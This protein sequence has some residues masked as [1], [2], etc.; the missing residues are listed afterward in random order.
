MTAS[1]T[2][3]KTFCCWCLGALPLSLMGCTAGKHVRRNFENSSTF[4]YAAEPIPAENASDGGPKPLVTMVGFQS[5]VSAARDLE[6][7]DQTQRAE[8]V[9]SPLTV[10]AAEQGGTPLS[11]ARTSEQRKDATS[12]S[13]T[14]VGPG[15]IREATAAPSIDYAVD[16]Y[17]AIDGYTV[18]DYVAMAIAAHPK[19][20]AANHR[21]AAAQNR[22]AQARSLAD[23]MLSETFWPFNG[24]A[25]E[26]A[27]GRAANQL[28]ISQAVPWPEKL[29]A[30][31]AIACREAQVV[32]AEVRRI[33]L[34]IVESVQLACYEIWFATR[35]LAVVAESGKLVEELIDI[36]EAR[37]RSGGSQQ[38]ILRAQ[39][40]A[41]R[42]AER[43]SQLQQQKRVAQADLATLLQTPRESALEVAL[44]S[45]GLPNLQDLDALIA[46]A[47]SNNPELRGLRSQISSDRAK[48]RLA[49]LQKYPDFQVGMN[50]MMVSDQNAISPV[51]NGND[52]FGFTVGMSLPIYREKIDAGIRESAHMTSSTANLLQSERDSIAGKLRRLLAQADSLIEQEQIYS[53]RIIP[54][55]E[56]A[57]KVSLA[58][59]RGKKTDFSSVIETYRELLQLQIQLARLD[60]SLAA[61]IAQVERTIGIPT[62]QF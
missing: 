23:P 12:D 26:T 28:G 62:Y 25:L 46:Q 7:N 19:I 1:N 29:A 52:N 2:L 57:L 44:D 31:E 37:Y 43:I 45:E 14:P 38:D 41:D 32:E 54:R 18:D 35:S 34:E 47:E 51:A 17:Y 8:G 59:Y 15:G 36:S 24:N 58:D 11:D 61:T 33:R 3:K 56:D 30:R 48:Q 50:W 53:E 60:T 4:A 27:G 10:A 9:S 42:L 5:P 55:T 39:L 6:L 21:L 13:A 16:G 22:I 40:E 20:A 49:G